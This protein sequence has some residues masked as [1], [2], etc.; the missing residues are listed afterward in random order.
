MGNILDQ[1]KWAL[2]TM[3]LFLGSLAVNEWVFTNLEFVRGINWIYLPA[4][5][6]LI[7]TLL[8]GLPAALGLLAG[9]WIACFCYYFPDDMLRSVA[10][11][12]MAAAAPYLAYRWAHSA[13]RL[14]PDLANLTAWRLLIC[15]VVY[16]VVN[17]TIHHLWFFLQGERAALADG[18]IAMLTGDITGS[19]F[20]LYTL[21]VISA[22]GRA[23]LRR[24][25]A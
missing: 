25:A 11:G 2:V 7:C 13:L 12:I 21:K 14:Q 16:A 6:R 18:F 15:A 9:S 10:G 24:R 4:G 17:T 22:L 8:F 20:V 19:L 5:V 3:A 1:G 23:V